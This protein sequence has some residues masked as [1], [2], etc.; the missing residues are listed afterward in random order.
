MLPNNL[1]FLNQLDKIHAQGR[2]QVFIQTPSW[3]APGDRHPSNIARELL[4]EFAD[5][6]NLLLSITSAPNR[7]P[8]SD[9]DLLALTTEKPQPATL[10]S[11]SYLSLE[12]YLVYRRN[13][14]LAATAPAEA[15][16]SAGQATPA[17]INTALQAI[18]NQQLR[19]ATFLAYDW[20]PYQ[21][22][23][24][25]LMSRSSGTTTEF[26]WAFPDAQDHSLYNLTEKFLAE[27][28]SSGYL[29]QL[30]EHFF[31]S[32]KQDVLVN[33]PVFSQHIDTRLT[34]L[35]PIFKGA[36]QRYQLDWRLLAAISYQESRWQAEAVSPTGVKGLMMLTQNTASAMG[37]ANR[38]N[39][40]QSI[41]AAA[42]YLQIIDQRLPD[43][44]TEPDRTWMALAAYNMGPRH[45]L[46]AIHNTEAAGNNGGNW[47]DVRQQLMQTSIRQ[48]NNKQRYLRGYDQARAYVRHV[49]AYYDYLSRPSFGLSKTTLDVAQNDAPKYAAQALMQDKNTVTL[50]LN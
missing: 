20:K 12:N 47:L 31:L 27:A 4:Q 30:Q 6:H 19:S 3:I 43:Y 18:A 11:R 32:T 36:A 23:L 13:D 24:P 14:P 25:K 26:R 29:A 9:Y 50:A 35:L 16:W 2:L 48:T 1:S 42:R 46:T 45:L 38:Q 37:I 8:N 49:R 7:D 15:N 33:G 21:T 40:T 28:Q 22:F 34:Q 10:L 5:E 41:Y 17:E 44:I 39:P